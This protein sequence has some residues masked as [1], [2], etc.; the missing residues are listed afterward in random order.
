[1]N[2]TH[3][4]QHDQGECR[5]QYQRPGGRQPGDRIVR[6]ARPTGH[7]G[8][9]EEPDGAAWEDLPAEQCPSE[10]AHGPH[11]WRGTHWKRCPG[12]VGRAGVEH[13]QGDVR[14]RQIAAAR[15]VLHHIGL[16][17]HIDRAGLAAELVDAVNAAGDDQAEVERLRAQVEQLR[18]ERRLL[19][20]ARMTMDLIAA[21]TPDRW[22][23]MRA[24]AEDVAQRIVDEIGHSV[25]D[26]PALGPDLRK[27]NAEL[28]A[29]VEN[30]RRTFELGYT[31][32]QHPPSRFTMMSFEGILRPC[33]EC[34]A[35]LHV[36]LGAP[37]L[38]VDL[39]I[40]GDEARG[41]G[42]ERH[43]GRHAITPH[44]EHCPTIRTEGT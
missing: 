34:R 4:Q 3:G 27:E 16:D 36:I 12:Y 8:A 43:I 41:T 31:G 5:A 40:I 33:E 30:L 2:D 11:D 23:R 13:D 10:R 7:D 18:Y 24:E 21:G 25:T 29:E 26:E 22:E 39:Y 20:V 1:M 9:H 32:D 15:D 37:R 17:S 38:P 19:G 14:A 44:T 28:R 35:P 42:W 6:C